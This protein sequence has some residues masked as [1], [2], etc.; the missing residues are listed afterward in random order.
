MKLSLEWDPGMIGIF[1][2]AVGEK[3]I[4]S[5]K[6][7]RQLGLKPSLV[8][9]YS[10]FMMLLD[11]WPQL[12]LTGPMI[13]TRIEDNLRSRLRRLFGRL[14]TGKK[15]ISSTL[16]VQFSNEVLNGVKERMLRKRAVPVDGIW[17]PVIILTENP[18][19]ISE[20]RSPQ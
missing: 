18:M 19:T 8:L 15:R 10:E 13:T 11:H 2:P 9:S 16:S 5:V 4:A 20:S 3:L 14:F 17:V 12:Y 1:S 7:I 6:N